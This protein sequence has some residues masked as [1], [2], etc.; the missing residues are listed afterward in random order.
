MLIATHYHTR[1][2]QSGADEA[3]LAKLKIACW[4]ESYPGILPQPVLDGLDFSRC[5][6][7]WGRALSRGIA[8]IGE[9]GDQPVGFGHMRCNEV[10]ML[11]VREAD[12]RHGLG[13]YLLNRLFDEIGCLGHREAHLWVLE[14]NAKAREFYRRMGGSAVAR[15]AV[16][17]AHYPDIM[18][19]R[20]DFRI[21]N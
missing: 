14:K 1:M 13:A 18:E 21:D 6:A 11:Y 4:R 12:Q 5:R 2:A 8:W 3:S 7:E 9:Q 20:Y 15:R 19:V 10:T 16:G 17:F